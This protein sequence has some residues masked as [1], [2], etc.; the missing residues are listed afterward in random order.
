MLVDAV[1]ID[2][3][4]V[5]AREWLEC[6]A[7]SS[8]SCSTLPGFLPVME[9]IPQHAHSCRRLRWS[10]KKNAVY[11]YRIVASLSASVIAVATGHMVYIWIKSF[12]QESRRSQ[13]LT[14]KGNF[15]DSMNR[16]L[17][18]GMI[19]SNRRAAVDAPIL[20]K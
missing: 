3:C 16:Q 18:V 9:P 20:N 4:Q 17:K 13:M 2:C 15:G 10:Q 12:C 11:I 7:H 6:T 19:Q 1:A 8:A 14:S 5:Y